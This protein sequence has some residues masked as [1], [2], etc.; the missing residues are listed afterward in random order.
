MPGPDEPFMA[1]FPEYTDL[2][3]DPMRQRITAGHVLTMTLGTQWDESGPAPKSESEMEHA[4]DIY[5]F[6]LDLP[7]VA[8]PGT[9]WTYN[10]GATNLLARVIAQG[11]ETPLESYARERLFA[12]LGIEDVEWVTDYYG[13]PWAS[14]GLRLR[15]RDL[16]KI[17]QL[18]L[19]D[20]TWNGALVVP[21]DWL[22]ASSRRDVAAEEGCHYGYQ[23]WLCA[24]EAGV[25]VIEASGRGGQELLIVPDLD[26]V[27]VVTRGKYG[28]P[29]A[30]RAAWSVL[31][32]IV[33]PSI[34]AP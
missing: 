6:A 32:G 13:A 1:A 18:V 20:G 21:P 5:R 33:V 22:D 34:D 29:D 11:T 27:L 14:S 10:S 17:G 16:A 19:Q 3:D 2:A 24:T 28:D 7:M 30:W 25:P 8:E 23:W 31:E 9:T 4:A 12:P 26:L 15:P